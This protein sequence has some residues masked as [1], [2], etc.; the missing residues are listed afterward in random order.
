MKR[1]NQKGFAVVEA[2][3]VVIVLGIIGGT[4]YYVWHSKQTA[5]KAYSAAT[6]SLT[7]TSA[8]PQPTVKLGVVDKAALP[9]GWN[10]ESID[11]TSVVVSNQGEGQDDANNCRVEVTKIIDDKAK[12]GDALYADVLQKRAET[13]GRDAKN[14]TYT[15]LDTE[16]MIINTTSDS[17]T[18]FTFYT[19]IDYPG[20]ST[21]AYYA[22]NGYIVGNRNVIYLSATCSSTDFSQAEQALAAITLKAE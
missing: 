11:D 19:R 18:A 6:K 21:P 7:T 9:E 8:T 15:R 1:T 13:A 10:V 12:L 3:L 22:K 14:L 4:G 16:S 17:K 20:G 5:D 2:L